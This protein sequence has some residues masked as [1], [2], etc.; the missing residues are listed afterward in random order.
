VVSAV[1]ATILF[2]IAVLD[3]REVGAMLDER[4]AEA[5]AQLRVTGYGRSV[6]STSEMSVRAVEDDKK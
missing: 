1:L 6:R 3:L 5:V 2:V 4:M